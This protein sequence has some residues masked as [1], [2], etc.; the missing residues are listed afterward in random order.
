[1]NRGYKM[2]THLLNEMYTK[3]PNELYGELENILEDI[4]LS[5]TT[6]NKKFSI[7]SE[8]KFNV[9]ARFPSTYFSALLIS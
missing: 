2:A 1:M 7:F 6:P 4:K 5:E 9:D 8:F 3:F